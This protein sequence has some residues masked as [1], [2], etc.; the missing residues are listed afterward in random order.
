MELPIDTHIAQKVVYDEVLSDSI[1]I[2]DFVFVL[3]NV[4]WCIVLTNALIIVP[5]SRVVEMQEIL[6]HQ[7]AEEAAEAEGAGPMS[8]LPA[9]RASRK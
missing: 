2:L 5:F 9:P 8:N 3:C 4:G 6:D 1:I 7:Q